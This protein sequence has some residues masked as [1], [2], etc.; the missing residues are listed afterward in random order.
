MA[1]RLGIS[2][3]D[4]LY[5]ILLAD[6]KKYKVSKICQDA[7]WKTVSRIDPVGDSDIKKLAAYFREEQMK[8]YRPFYD[9]GFSDG[10]NNAFQID[11][12][13][14]EMF[15]EGYFEGLAPI[16]LWTKM[17]SIAPEEKFNILLTSDDK[18][19]AINDFLKLVKGDLCKKG[20]LT[21]DGSF[22]KN[23]LSASTAAMA[24]MDGWGNGLK[25]VCEELK[26]ELTKGDQS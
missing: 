17:E 5:E 22:A 4:E 25:S 21:K 3:P 15:V 12:A 6:K 11:Y 2:I 8:T 26:E 20:F 24:Y 10:V 7:L 13:K 1:K 16:D 19:A 9:E 23:W 18:D 14:L